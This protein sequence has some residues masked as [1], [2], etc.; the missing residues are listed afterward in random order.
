MAGSTEYEF[1]CEKLKEHLEEIDDIKVLKEMRVVEGRTTALRS[2]DERI[3]VIKINGGIF[4]D[5]E[6]FDKLVNKVPFGTR[7]YDRIPI[8]KTIQE[9]VFKRDH[10]TCRMCNGLVSRDTVCHH[11]IPSGKATLDNLVTICVV[12]HDIVHTF[13]GRKGY[14]RPRGGYY[15]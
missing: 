4:I 10:Y 1:S 6:V 7:Y 11:I 8:A 3:R 9:K 5:L 2:I 12:C 13:L 14:K 15:L